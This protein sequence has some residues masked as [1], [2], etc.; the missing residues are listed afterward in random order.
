M[1]FIAYAFNA[2]E[3]LLRDSYTFFIFGGGPCAIVVLRGPMSKKGPNWLIIN[4][5]DY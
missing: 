5:L 3:F 2:Y 4:D 1:Y